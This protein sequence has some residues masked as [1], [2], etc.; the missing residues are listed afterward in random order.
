MA[1]LA[2]IVIVPVLVLVLGSAV[3]SLSHLKQLDK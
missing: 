2:E 1:R 3:V